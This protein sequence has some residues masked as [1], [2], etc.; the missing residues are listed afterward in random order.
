MKLELDGIGGKRAARQPR[1]LHGVLAFLDPLF[2]CAALIVEADDTF[3]RARQVPDDEADAGIKL[4]RVHSTLAATRRGPALRLIAETG[5]E[6]PDLGGR[7]I[8]RAR[9]QVGDVILEHLIGGSRIAYLHP[10][11]SSNA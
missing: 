6:P 11:A 2:G 8:D 1:P 4:A 5:M 7:T 3:G 10:S 9:E